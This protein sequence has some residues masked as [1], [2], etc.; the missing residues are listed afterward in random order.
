MAGQDGTSAVDSEFVPL[1]KC[2]EYCASK[3]LKCYRPC[4]Q[5]LMSAQGG[6]IR[7]RDATVASGRGA[8]TF[9][10]APAH[11][12]FCISGGWIREASATHPKDS[13]GIE[14][15]S[16]TALPWRFRIHAST[17][18]K[19]QSCSSLPRFY[20]TQHPVSFAHLM[21]TTIE[22]RVPGRKTNSEPLAFR[23]AGLQWLRARQALL[24]TCSTS[25]SAVGVITYEGLV[26]HGDVPGAYP[27]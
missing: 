10:T 21:L 25:T 22:I 12:S 4:S 3:E 9:P 26:C 15:N 18:S 23:I 17:T 8:P 16:Y 5:I 13:A 1:V 2:S 14:T 11:L 24:Y 6:G 7:F 27:S 20:H 19:E